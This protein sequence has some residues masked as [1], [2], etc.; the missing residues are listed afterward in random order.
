MVPHAFAAFNDLMPVGVH[1]SYPPSPGEAGTVSSH[2]TAKHG[3]DMQQVASA[4][5]V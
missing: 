4:G 3:F 1:I 5:A 2:T